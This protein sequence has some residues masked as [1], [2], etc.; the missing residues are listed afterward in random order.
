MATRDRRPAEMDDA[1][2]GW[3][4]E[5]RAGIKHCPQNHCVGSRLAQEAVVTLAMV[6]LDGCL[7]GQLMSYRVPTLVPGRVLM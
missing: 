2:S 4:G 3:I 7:F 6:F 5:T 1:P